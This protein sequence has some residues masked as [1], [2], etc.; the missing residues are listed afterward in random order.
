MRSL[1]KEN[2]RTM[3]NLESSLMLVKRSMLPVCSSFTIFGAMWETI[4]GTQ[5]PVRLVFH[6]NS[7]RYLTFTISC[8]LSDQL[9]GWLVGWVG[10]WVWV[11]GWLVDWLV[12]WLG[13]VG[14]LVGWL[15]GSGW[16]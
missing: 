9:V 14:W 10:G 7:G 4:L 15:V 12:G 2:G 5:A 13:L 8:I 1:L 3:L 16:S 11:V 6:S